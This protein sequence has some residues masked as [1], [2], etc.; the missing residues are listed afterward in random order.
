MGYFSELDRRLIE[1]G[2][3]RGTPDYDRALFW[4]EVGT[5]QEGHGL[6]APCAWRCPDRDEEECPLFRKYGTFQKG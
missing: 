6:P 1:K 2:L 4:A 3:K 5:C